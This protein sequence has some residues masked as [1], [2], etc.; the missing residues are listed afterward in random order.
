MKQEEVEEE[1]LQF[2]GTLSEFYY[3]IYSKKKSNGN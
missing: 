1:M 2:E 3:Y